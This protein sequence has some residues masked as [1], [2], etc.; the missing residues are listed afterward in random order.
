MEEK[1]NLLIENLEDFK[2]FLKISKLNPL[3]K[4][5]GTELL[6]HNISFI[7]QHKINLPEGWK[8]NGRTYFIVDFFLPFYG[9]IIETDGKIHQEEEQQIKDRYKDNVLTS[10]NFRIF[11]FNWD[12]VMKK[13]ENW[14][15]FYLVELLI[16]KIDT[17]KAS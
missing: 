7:S 10:L 16:E 9:I 11:R 1:Q 6:L 14:D 8:V 5:M 13:D 2:K 4:V 17:E 3:E 15:I 12:E